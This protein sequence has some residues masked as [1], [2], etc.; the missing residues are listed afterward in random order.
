MI[1]KLDENEEYFK[2][3]ECDAAILRMRIEPNGNILP[4]GLIREP[5]GNI[6]DGNIKNIWV[7]DKIKKFRKSDLF[8][9]RNECLDCED[10]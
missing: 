7:S 6:Y 4:C 8:K 1:L 10:C 9:S 5:I 2:N 3:L